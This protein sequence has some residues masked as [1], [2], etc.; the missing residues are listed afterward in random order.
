MIFLS[1][2]LQ[3]FYSLKQLIQFYLILEDDLKIPF[4]IP[5][6][7]KLKARSISPLIQTTLIIRDIGL[8]I[9]AIPRS[10]D[11]YEHPIN[12]AISQQLLVNSRL[13][14]FLQM[15]HTQIPFDHE[16]VWCIT[17]SIFHSSSIIHCGSQFRRYVRFQ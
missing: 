5:T 4:I 3:I 2:N 7:L 11:D 6:P 10:D 12:F 15:D 14:I 8:S 9:P 16:I 17:G 1:E 13:I